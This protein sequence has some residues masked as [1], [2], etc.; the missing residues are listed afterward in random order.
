MKIL[1]YAE[2]DRHLT[3]ALETDPRVMG[4]LGG[5]STPDVVER[6]HRWR[7]E[8]PERGDIFVTI[9][10]DGSDEPVGVV[11]IWRSEIDGETVHEL[12]AMIL[13]G[14]QAQG[15]GTETWDLVRPLVRAAGITRLDS[16]PGVDNAASNAILRR[17]GFTRVGERDLDYEGRPVRC[18]HWTRDV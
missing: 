12:G 11:G 18:A 9:V 14:H 8:A 13:P 4:H 17:I 3:V 16:Y 5:V 6:V 7:L 1:P 2:P 10:P 15:V